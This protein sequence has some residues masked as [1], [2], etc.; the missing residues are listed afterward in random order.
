MHDRYLVQCS[1][2]FKCSNEVRMSYPKSHLD[3]VHGI[4]VGGSSNCSWVG[5]PEERTRSGA[6]CVGTRAKHDHCSQQKKPDLNA[7]ATPLRLRYFLVTDA[8]AK[9]VIRTQHTAG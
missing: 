1:N 8:S 4:V 5:G 2:V 3:I 7:R 6:K 9:V